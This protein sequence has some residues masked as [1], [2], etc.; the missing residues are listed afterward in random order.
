MLVCMENTPP[1]Q[2]PPAAAEAWAPPTLDMLAVE[3]NAA[4][5]VTTNGLSSETVNTLRDRGIDVVEPDTEPQTTPAED[6]NAPRQEVTD[7]ARTSDSPRGT[8]FIRAQRAAATT[9]AHTAP[10]TTP[11]TATPPPQTTERY[12]VEIPSFWDGEVWDG[13]Y[14]NLPENM[15]LDKGAMS[16]RQ[17]MEL[18][19]AGK[20]DVYLNNI[21]D[22][23]PGVAK[24]N[25]EMQKYVSEWKDK[26]PDMN[27]RILFALPD[28]KGIWRDYNGNP[29]SEQ[30]ARSAQ[31][32]AKHNPAFYQAAA[33]YEISKY[34]EPRITE[35]YER[36]L[37]VMWERFH[38][39][40]DII[41]EVMI[42]LQFMNKG[43]YLYLKH[44]GLEHPPIVEMIDGVPHHK[45][46]AKVKVDTKTGRPVMHRG[47]YV[48]ET[49]PDG[50]PVMEKMLDE[51]K[52]VYGEFKARAYAHELAEKFNVYQVGLRPADIA[53]TKNLAEVCLNTALEHA[54]A[55][56]LSNPALQDALYVLSRLNLV[57]RASRYGGAMDPDS[58]AAMRAQMEMADQGRNGG[59]QRGPQA[60][61]AVRVTGGPAL[62]SRIW[63]DIAVVTDLAAEIFPAIEQVNYRDYPTLGRIVLGKRKHDRPMN[64][65]GNNAPRT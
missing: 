43:Q 39:R 30:M 33:A 58:D 24:M 1:P 12:N 51:H 26:A 35:V 28:E 20:A 65:K 55:G 48:Y 13:D 21:F 14:A 56:D 52:L 5:Q 40:T 37:N 44:L 47:K 41:K 8:R 60:K 18:F 36:V 10:P 3:R 62:T 11:P 4:G 19:I 49:N 16:A 42:G 15:R 25:D 53:Q 9:A 32:R 45:M 23:E 31:K 57:V 38:Y 2:M 17:R 61:S 59:N 7:S 22:F 34:E 29:V 46:Q 63:E 27:L 54:R 50:T 6:T 64:A